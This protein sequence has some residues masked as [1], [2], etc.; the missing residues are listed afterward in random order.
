MCCAITVQTW[1]ELAA[2]RSLHREAINIFC[3]LAPASSLANSKEQDWLPWLRPY[4]NKA[5]R[6]R[7]YT[8]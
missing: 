1:A 4:K 3:P 7:S 6:R 8:T 5:R 2:L